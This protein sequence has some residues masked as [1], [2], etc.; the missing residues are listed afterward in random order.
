MNRIARQARGAVGVRV[1]AR[2]REHALRHQLPQ[3]MID[4]AGLSLLLQTS[5]Q[6]IQQSQATI[7]SLQQQSAAV[8][9]TISLIK[10]SHHRFAKNSWEQQTLCCAI[11]RHEEA[12]NCASNSV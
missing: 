8:R 1:A 11:F 12:S 3:G 5:G 6:F 2:N 7:G 10:M 9:A 4:L